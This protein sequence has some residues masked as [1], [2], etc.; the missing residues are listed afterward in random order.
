MIEVPMWLYEVMKENGDL[1]ENDMYYGI[2]VI[3]ITPIPEQFEIK[4]GDEE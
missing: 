2:K 1:D 4:V 3:P